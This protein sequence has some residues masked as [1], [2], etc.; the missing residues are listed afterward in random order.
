MLWASA[1]GFFSES[2]GACADLVECIAG[3]IV[4]DNE[5]DRAR[6][7]RYFEQRVATHKEAS[8]LAVFIIKPATAQAEERWSERE[9]LIVGIRHHSPACARL[10]KSLIESQRP[11][12]PC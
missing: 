7:R 11:I 8:T 4:K 3:T 10:V 9:L 5:E 2:R 12:L 6:L 1:P